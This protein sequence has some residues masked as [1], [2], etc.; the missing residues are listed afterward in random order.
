MAFDKNTTVCFA[1]HRPK[2]LCGYDEAK[3]VAARRQLTDLVLLMAKAGKTS[4][5]TGGA[6]G[7]D[8]LA[9]WAVA[10]ARTDAAR[11]GYSIRNVL[12]LPFPGFGSNWRP[13][14]AFSRAQLEIAIR[15]ADEVR[16]ASDA[17]PVDKQ[18][19]VRLLMARNEAML[20]LSGTLV[21]VCN[22]ADWRDPAVRSGTAAA[23]RSALARDMRVMRVPY[24]IDAGGLYLDVRAAVT[25]N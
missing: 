14:G 6:Q 21:A 23:M 10:H 7:I 9:F 19:A 15:C 5:I 25:E 18:H 13:D 20:D 3:Y 24:G 16:Y 8:Q 22:L 1:G 4:F 12:V 11:Q 2:A 17:V